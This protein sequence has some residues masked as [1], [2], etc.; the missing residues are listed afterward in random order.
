M[1]RVVLITGAASGLGWALSR[2]HLSAGDQ[3]V[4]VD[5]DAALLQQRE[6]ECVDPQQIMT[7]LCDVT[8]AQ[9]LAEMLVK[10]DQRFGRLDVLVN[11]AGI[12]HRSAA[13]ETD[14]SVFKKVMAVDWQG[15]VEL[16]QLALPMLK[17]SAGQIVC[18]GSMAGWM[19][20]P[21]RAA[22]CAAKSALAQ[23]FEVLRLEVAADDVSVLMVYPSFL[24]TPIERNAL[25]HD[26]EQ[27][28]HA[29][30]TV[31]NIR[32][33]DWMAGKILQAVDRRQPW[34]FPDRLSAFAS[35]LWRVWPSMYL[36]LIRRRFASELQR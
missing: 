29:R 1:S 18:I 25:G 19:P 14:P 21:G 20:V 12:T 9:Q 5:R 16:T 23:F 26:G 10:V 28:K 30:S 34:L 31:G 2:A 36:R 11:N 32:S 13:A 4:L 27:A 3:V 17:R 22:Y 6:Q 8:D 7:C 35:I 33:A 24:D 15:P